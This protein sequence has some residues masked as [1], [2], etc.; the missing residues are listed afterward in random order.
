MCCNAGYTPAR[1]IRRL[2]A[3][4]TQE[5]RQGLSERLLGDHADQGLAGAAVDFDFV[6]PGH[7]PGPC[8]APGSTPAAC[9][10]SCRR[11]RGARPAAAMRRG[12][13]LPRSRYRS[14]RKAGNRMDASF[15]SA[16]SHHP[17]SDLRNHPS[18]KPGHPPVSVHIPGLPSNTLPFRPRWILRVAPPATR[19]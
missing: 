16:G 2:P 12:S 5:G 13:R 7:L 11:S 9:N 6:I 14:G 1:G 15:V 17:G 4:I 18:L 8:C 10:R 3:G 19:L